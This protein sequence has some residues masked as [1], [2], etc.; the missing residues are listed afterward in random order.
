MARSVPEWIGKTDDDRV[1][2]RVQLR[3]WR[4]Q[5][6][7]NGDTH[8]GISGDIMRPGDD[9]QLDHKVALILNGGHRESN[10]HFV[11]TRYHRQKTSEEVAIRAG[12]DVRAKTHAGIK[13]TELTGLEGRTPQQKRAARDRKTAMADKL[14]QAARRP[15]FMDETPPPLLLTKGKSQ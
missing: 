6:D 10:L 1:P 7:V 14:P 12:N 4:S 5:Q 2:E 3:I 13:T 8:C 9:M 11:L 15:M